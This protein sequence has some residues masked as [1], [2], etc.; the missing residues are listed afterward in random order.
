[1][2]ISNAQLKHIGELFNESFINRMVFH[3][4]KQ[5][6]EWADGR[7]EADCKAFISAG[8]DAASKYKIQSGGP[9]KTY[10]S[11]WV[12]Y[13]RDFEKLPEFELANEILRTRNITEYKKMDRLK[14]ELPII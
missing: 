2:E 14:L 12:K 1:M 5:S 9:V 6:P 10:L 3:F 11:Y 7:T 4:S 13:G 8:I